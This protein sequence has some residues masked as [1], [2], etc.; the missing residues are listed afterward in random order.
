MRIRFV[1]Q[2]TKWDFFKKIRVWL[3][4]SATLIFISL[5]SFFIQG[6]NFGIDFLGGTTIRTQSSQPVDVGSYRSALGS[7][8]LGDVTISEVFDPSF[9]DD[10]N[11][12]IIKVQQQDKTVDSVNEITPKALEALRKVSSDI[13]FVS[14]ESV[15]PK[16]SKELIK[17]A[18]LAVQP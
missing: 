18:V 15:G 4:L 14:I 8:N 13:S 9:A 2:N 17:K 10:Q 6:F 16:V 7:L 12:A 11:V 3:G 1:P 5:M